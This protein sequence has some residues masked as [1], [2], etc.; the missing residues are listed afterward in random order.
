MVL[1]SLLEDFGSQLSPVPICR[2][3]RG[4]RQILPT[5]VQRGATTLEPRDADADGVQEEVIINQDPGLSPSLSRNGPK[6]AGRS[7]A[8]LENASAV[9]ATE[10]GSRIQFEIRGYDRPPYK[11]Q[12]PFGVEGKMQ[13]Q[14]GAELSVLLHA[15]KNGRLFELEFIR[16][17]KET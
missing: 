9:P 12:H 5:S 1:F 11:G 14:D 2:R 6:K 13:D 16:C 7:L 15:D 17:G 8:D 3:N 4:E 10:D